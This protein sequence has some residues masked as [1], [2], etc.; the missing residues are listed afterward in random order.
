GVDIGRIE[1][2]DVI[3][4]ENRWINFHTSSSIAREYERYI[5]WNMSLKIGIVGMPNVGKST[6]F[7]ALTKKPV[8]IANYPFATIDPNVGVVTVPDER[9]V[10]LAELSR[11]KK[12]IPAI[13]EFVDIA[14]LV[15][16]AAEGLGLGNAFLSHI[17]DVDAILH[18]VR[19]FKNADIIHVE[20]EPNPVRDFETIN[21]ELILKDLD[22]ASHALEKAETEARSSD[23]QKIERR[24]ML[25]KLKTALESETLLSCSGPG[26][27]EITLADQIGL[28]TQKP[29][30]VVFNIADDEIASHWQPDAGLTEALGKI[31]HLAIAI[32]IEAEAA[33][34]P[35][36][37][38]SEFREIAGIRET[39]F[40]ALTKKSYK[41]LGLM[42][43]FTTG[44]DES[45]AWTIPQGSTAPRAGRAIHSDFEE[46]FIRAEVIQWEKLIEAGSWAKARESG[47]LRT[48]G[49]DYIVKDGDVIEFK[50]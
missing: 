9:L 7:Q 35:E 15:K 48:E 38:A 32:G 47:T 46:K 45:R 26:K 49:R 37:E 50:I 16:G 25:K 41:T 12:V 31:P 44:E 36:T 42:T 39:G 33:A 22:T 10:K 1:T 14:G 20:K 6:L 28:L 29:M 30:L 24:D 18:V 27:A 40:E 19:V 11:S 21:L 43:F 4:P 2:A 8:T 5:I 13:I 23:P 34:L 3:S 17:R